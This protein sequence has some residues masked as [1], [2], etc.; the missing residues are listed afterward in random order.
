[1]S[2]ATTASPSP[3]MSIA[4][5]LAKYSILRRIWAGHPGFP[6]RTA[7]SPSTRLTGALQTGQSR[8]MRKGRSEPSRS[9]TSTVA[10]AGMTSPAFSTSTQSPIRRSLRAIS[11]SLCSVALATVLPATRTGSSSATGVRTPLR[12]TCT[13]M[14]SRR[15]RACSGSYL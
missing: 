13:V 9:A 8:G 15:V 12:P 1:M 2:C 11:S 4:L 10:I 7:T 3:A 14:S 6:H 5:R